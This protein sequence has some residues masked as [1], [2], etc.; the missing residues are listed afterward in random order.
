MNLA[1]FDSFVPFVAR[2]ILFTKPSYFKV[3]LM[4]IIWLVTKPYFGD[5]LA[6]TSELPYEYNNL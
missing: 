6:E 1:T 4:K 5:K 3:D 2:N